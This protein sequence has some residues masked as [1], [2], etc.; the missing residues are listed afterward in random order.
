M[1]AGDWLSR[2][3]SP[4]EF[5]VLLSAAIVAAHAAVAELF[6]PSG[7]F[8]TEVQLVFVEHPSIIHKVHGILR[9]MGL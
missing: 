9:F 8:G 5:S 1:V 3:P 6:P 4:L 2:Y 7:A